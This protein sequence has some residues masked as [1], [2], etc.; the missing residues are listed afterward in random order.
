L[1]RPQRLAQKHLFLGN[2]KW[3]IR[4]PRFKYLRND[5]N[6]VCGQVSKAA[7]ERPH[8][9]LSLGHNGFPTLSAKLQIVSTGLTLDAQ[10]RIEWATPLK[11]LDES[12]PSPEAHQPTTK[13][14]SGRTLEPHKEPL[15][16][17]S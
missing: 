12:R 4:I 2:Q 16:K 1:T 5:G 6:K 3:P 15:G 10:L 11:L 13:A 14:N 8:H 17:V 7:A 9:R